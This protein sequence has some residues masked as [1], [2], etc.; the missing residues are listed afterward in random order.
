MKRKKTVILV[1]MINRIIKSTVMRAAGKR[2]KK[3]V[4]VKIILTARV[5]LVIT[6][7]GVGK[8]VVEM[9]GSMT[10]VEV[11]IGVMAEVE[12]GIRVMAEVGIGVMAEVGIDHTEEVETEVGI[13]AEI[14]AMKEAMKEVNQRVALNVVNQKAGKESMKNT[15]TA[16]M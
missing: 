4:L 12:A 11:G 13:G 10:E 2:R 6:D 5:A 1:S 7:P 3:E 9:I 16:I 15:Q 8:E 14:E